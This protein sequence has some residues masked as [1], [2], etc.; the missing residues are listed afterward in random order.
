MRDTVPPAG[1]RY[2]AYEGHFL[3]V[4]GPPLPEHKHRT[5]QITLI[6]VFAA[7]GLG[8]IAISALIGG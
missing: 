3:R 7:G 6:A 5:R 8:G 1:R 4:P 2:S